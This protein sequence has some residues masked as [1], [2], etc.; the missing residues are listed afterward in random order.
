MLPPLPGDRRRASTTTSAATTALERRCTLAS[1]G[2]PARRGSCP[3]A[4]FLVGLSSIHWREAWKYGERAFRYCQHDAG[5]ALAAVRYAA[6]GAGLVG[7][8]A[9]TGLAMTTS[10]ALLGLDRDADFA[11][12]DAADREHPERAPASSAVRAGFGP[13]PSWPASSAEEVVA[14]MRAGVWSGR[15]NPL[16]PRARRL[17]SHR[18]GRP[19][20]WQP[21]RR[22]ADASPFRPAAAAAQPRPSSR[23]PAATLIRQRRSCPGARRPDRPSRPRPSTRMLDRLLP[24]PGVPPWDVLPWAPQIHLGH[25]RPPRPRAWPRACTSSSGPSAHERLRAALRGEF[26]WERPDG[27]PGRTCAVPAWPDGPAA[28][29]AAR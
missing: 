23:T 15:A 5:H 8:L 21:G 1:G 9:G 26:L 4:A 6:G 12:V 11:G 28:N 17:G 13:T 18:P 7:A 20:H 2:G 24:R 25:L 14:L 19:G 29:V 10:S 16:S 3:P 22:A 27:L